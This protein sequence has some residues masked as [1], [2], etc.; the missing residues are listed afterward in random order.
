MYDL[1]E[2]RKEFPIL[3]KKIYGKTL[4]YLDNGASAQKPKRVLEVINKTYSSEYANVH[5]GLHYLSNI[6]TD[7]FEAV[8]D[9]VKNFLG[10]SS[11]A[12]IVFTS[13]T[14]ESI[15]LIS[16]GWGKPNLSKGDEII[17]SV[18]EHH[19]NIVPWHF[20]RESIGVV[21]KWVEPR[22][23]GSISPS[24]VFSK[25]TSDTKLIALTHMSNVLGSILDVK[26][27]CK[28]EKTKGIPVLVD[29]SQ[30]AVHMGVDVVDIGCDFY[31]ITGHKLYGPSGSGAIYIKKKRLNEMVPFMGGGSMIGDVGRDRISF[32]E[33]PH[34][35]E[36]GTP[37]IVEIIGLG[38]AIDFIQ[39]IGFDNIRNHEVELTNY[40][41]AELE[42]LNWLSLY[43]KAKHRGAIFSF[44][45]EGQAHSHDISTVL[46]RKGI[47]VRAGHH[48]A[49][50]LMEYLGITASCRA[51]FALYNTK[52]E[53]DSLIFGL[54]DCYNLFN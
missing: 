3:D 26:A 29:G 53:V 51:S 28:S 18:M 31:C 41:F 46:D 44:N 38:A 34:R 37:G 35:F 6:A 45:I 17:L 40:A 39:D 16:Y 9:K 1:N 24:D 5:R 7:N 42:N 27:I 47:A 10:A 14:T 25:I 54:K 48:C 12:E 33:I 43:G 49:Q 50:P 36:A 32:N 4:C 52:N 8:R 30:A 19:A 20:L 15:N 22:K 23:D 2:I 21:L 11:S 13:G